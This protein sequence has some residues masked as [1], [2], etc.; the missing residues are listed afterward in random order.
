MQLSDEA[1]TELTEDM[2]GDLL[3]YLPVDTSLFELFGPGVHVAVEDGDPIVSFGSGDILGAFG[4]RGVGMGGEEMLAIPV[5]LP[6]LTRP[7]K[8]LVELE[9]PDEALSILR[10][11]AWRSPGR[12]HGWAPQVDFYRLADRDA[13]ICK[14][15][16]QGLIN[17][18]YRVSVEGD[19]LVICNLPWS[20]RTDL[21][22]AEAAPLNA[23]R[24]ELRPG[25][26]R[27]ELGAL[28]TSAAEKRRAAAM[29]GLAQL[30]P[31]LRSVSGSP[32]EAVR[33]C[34]RLLG[35]RPV[36]PGSGRWTEKEGA[37]GSSQF[38]T[39]ASPKQPSYGGD[40]GDFGIFGGLQDL[41]VNMQLEDE[42]LRTILRWK[43]AVVSP[44]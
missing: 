12:S 16:I 43:P 21:A 34:R 5:I 10:R 25:A 24:L 11:P 2:Y 33:D 37:I 20:Q 35:F 28:Y 29:R 14:I 27:R 39:V 18:R 9:D 42:G 44:H 8:I 32:E 19:Y 17:L 13:W 1:W 36:H 40:A 4:G 38:G 3:R 6:L 30:Y 26:V 31:L 7:S 41:S 22:E 15:D 23:A